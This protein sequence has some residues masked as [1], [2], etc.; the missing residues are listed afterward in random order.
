MSKKHPEGN[1]KFT[2]NAYYFRHDL[3]TVKGLF[4]FFLEIMAVIGLAY[5]GGSPFI[6]FQF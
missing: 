5:T 4:L 1:G 2:L 3:S 6:Y